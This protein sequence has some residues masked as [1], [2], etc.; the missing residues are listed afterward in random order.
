MQE[1]H[2]LPSSIYLELLLLSIISFV[3]VHGIEF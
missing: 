1:K 3:H 2:N